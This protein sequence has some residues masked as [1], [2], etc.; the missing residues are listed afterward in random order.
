[1][2]P[3]DVTRKTRIDVRDIVLIALLSAVGGVLSTYIGYLGNLINRLF[4]V[5]FGAG[6]LIAGLHILWPLLARA[7]VGRFGAGTLTGLTKGAVEL[8]SGGTHGVIILLVSA[9]EGLFVDLGL[10]ITRKRRLA[11]TMVTGAVSSAANVF[12]FQAVYFSGVSAT[13][14]LMM[15]GLSAVSGAF[16]GGY[17]AWDLERLLVASRVVRPSPDRSFGST[18]KRPPRKTG[19]MT[20]PAVEGRARAATPRWRRAW[21]RNV[22]TLAI[23]LGLLAGGVYYYLEVFDPF[24]AP[25]S[26]RIE[27]EVF[28]PYTFVYSAWEGSETTVNTELRGSSSY[29]PA[30][31]YTGFPVARSAEEGD[32]GGRGG[33][34]RD[35]RVRRVP[36]RVHAFRPPP[37]YGCVDDPRGRRSSAH[38]PRGRRVVLG[39]TGG[40]DCRPLDRSTLNGSRFAIPDVIARRSA[41]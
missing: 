4:G 41:T 15:A 25:G 28:A 12:V 24:S 32:P 11:V 16:F 27:G 1:M 8:F 39:Q 29:I 9:V 30:R 20:R 6:Q 33:D 35:D 21:T 13:Y 14:I 31:D 17:L 19:F 36:G 37:G 18:A 3:A 34:R 26:A 2:D 10:G 38:R 5:P 40:A 22:I 23:V 7:F